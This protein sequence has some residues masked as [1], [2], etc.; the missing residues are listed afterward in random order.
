LEKFDNRVDRIHVGLLN[1]QHL[2]GFTGQFISAH[3]H[4]LEQGLEPRPTKE[5]EHHLDTQVGLEGLD[6]AAT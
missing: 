5:P 1:C 6:P 2:F 3:A 4:L